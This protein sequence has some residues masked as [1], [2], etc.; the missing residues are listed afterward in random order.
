[1]IWA[2]PSDL[3]QPGMVLE[4]REPLWIWLL[5]LPPLLLLLVIRRPCGAT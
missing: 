5:L 3:W 4:L 2:S 1:M